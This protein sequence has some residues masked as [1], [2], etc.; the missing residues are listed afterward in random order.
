MD[1]RSG[2][3]IWCDCIARDEEVSPW[4]KD[5][6]ELVIEDMQRQITEL[7]KRW[8]GIGHRKHAQI[9]C[10]MNTLIGRSEEPKGTWKEW[11]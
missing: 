2:R 10:K 4:E 3:R 5:V 6:Q 1:K 7:K 8:L 9:D 11:S